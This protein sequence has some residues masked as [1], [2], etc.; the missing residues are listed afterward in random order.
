MFDHN[1]RQFSA[2]V[3]FN[4]GLVQGSPT[5]PRARNRRLMEARNRV[6]VFWS[7]RTLCSPETFLHA[8]PTPT[9]HRREER[10]GCLRKS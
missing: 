1:D 6:F 8:E 5:L 2:S 10:R 9:H 4:F 7:S 3:R